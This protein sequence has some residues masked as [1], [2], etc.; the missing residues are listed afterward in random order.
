[1]KM[2]KLICVCGEHSSG[3]PLPPPPSL[4]EVGRAASQALASG[5]LGLWAPTQG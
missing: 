5:A 2:K 4:L 3:Q 1:M